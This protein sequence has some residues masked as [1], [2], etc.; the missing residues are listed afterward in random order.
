MKTFLTRMGKHAKFMITGN[1]DQVDLPPN[2]RSGLD[3]SDGPPQ[4]D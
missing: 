1:P 4:R 2:Q 3:R